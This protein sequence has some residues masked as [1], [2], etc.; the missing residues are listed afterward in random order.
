MQACLSLNHTAGAAVTRRS[1]AQN[2]IRVAR[3]GATK[4]GA[5]GGERSRRRRA[6]SLVVRAAD[7]GWSDS[8]Q[9]VHNGERDGRPRVSDSL[10]TPVCMT[11][12]YW[13]KDTEELIAYQEGRYGSFEYGRYGN[14]TA[15]ACEEKIRL[16]EGGE[17]CLLSAS[18]EEKTH[19]CFAF[20]KKTRQKK[21]KKVHTIRWLSAASQR[22]LSFAPLSL[23]FYMST[24]SHARSFSLSLSHA[25]PPSH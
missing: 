15:R 5:A 20:I 10:T 19:H 23:S 16:L 17:D 22:F 25:F 6:P 11:S 14:P 12:T 2:Q 8:T 9:A 18:G 1:A 7:E 21:K 24:L 13:F 3:L 4:G